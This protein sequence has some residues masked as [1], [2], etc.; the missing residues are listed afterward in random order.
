MLARGFARTTGLGAKT[1]GATERKLKDG[2]E[3]AHVAVTGKEL[4]RTQENLEEVHAAAGG[5]RPILSQT[6]CSLEEATREARQWKEAAVTAAAW[7]TKIKEERGVLRVQLTKKVDK[8]RALKDEAAKL[9]EG[10]AQL[11]TELADTGTRR[12]REEILENWCR[13]KNRL[14]LESI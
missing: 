4:R 2:E 7:M 1:Q 3:E 5:Q 10:S 12:K 9:R 14:G 13:M 6:M 11:R 8:N